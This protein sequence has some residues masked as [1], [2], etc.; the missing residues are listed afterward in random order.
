MN[1]AIRMAESGYLP[2]ALI[3]FGIR[4]LLRQRLSEERQ[5]AGAHEPGRRMAERL[6]GE[7]IAL[8]TERANE[9]HYE[10]PAGFFRLMLGPHLKYSSCHWSSTE[11]TLEQAEEEM[12]RLS[13][14]RARIEDG[15][16][17][18]DL[19]CGWGS[20]SL[21]IAGRYPRCRVTAVSSS[22]SQAGFIRDRAEWK[23]LRN[24]TV[25]TEDINH[26]DAPRQ[27]DRIV[28]IE[29]FEHLRNY[30]LLLSRLAGWMHS[31]GKLFVHIF[32]HRHFA[33][34]FEIDGNNDWM[35]RHFF[36]GGIMPSLDLLGRFDRDLHVVNQ[37][38]VEGG[39]Y[40]R[41]L[42][43]WLRNLDDRRE[44]ALELLGA[45][46]G[47][48]EARLWFVRWRLFLLGCAELFGY[49]GGNEWLVS[50][51]LLQKGA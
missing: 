29:M 40:R 49:N 32:C 12:L 18:L 14:E 8:A 16:E 28:S 33:Y 21:W 5:R 2:D 35:A 34:P 27:Y 3:R 31:D 37:W 23:K 51:Y 11:Q 48:R 10:V 17:V 44:A 36:T 45:H 46:Y 26:F 25:L 50:H 24:L 38:N 19:G 4:R 9:Q 7:P 6:R 22:A 39:H 20:M 43:A 47:R 13:C 15:M 42:L 30:E 1:T 41:T